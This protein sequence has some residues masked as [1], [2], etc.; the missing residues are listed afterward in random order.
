MFPS[1][2]MSHEGG[3]HS[4]QS[5]T[6]PCQ[7][8]LRG[9]CWCGS[10][11]PPHPRPLW[12]W[13]PGTSPLLGRCFGSA[14]GETTSQTLQAK[15]WRNGG[16]QRNKRRERVKGAC[17]IFT[18]AVSI[19]YWIST[20]QHKYKVQ[21]SQSWRLWAILVTLNQLYQCTGNFFSV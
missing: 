9:R 15:R 8:C 11:I 10:C 7:S 16:K 13:W 1:T 19:N 17:S 21:W 6:P 4:T 5:G 2:A 3:T 18:A 14:H 20:R 12:S